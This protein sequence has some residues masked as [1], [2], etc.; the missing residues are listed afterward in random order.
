MPKITVRV[1]GLLAAGALALAVMLPSVALAADPDYAT[2]SDHAAFSAES[3]DPAFWCEN[4]TKVDAVDGNLGF[5]QVLEMDYDKVIVKAGANEQGN[6]AN[7]IFNNPTA[8]QTVWADTN[9]NNQYDAEKVG[10]VDADKLISHIIF[11]PAAVATA[12]PSDEVNPETATPSDDTLPNTSTI[13]QTGTPSSGLPVILVLGIAG[14][15][16]ILLATAPVA[17]RNRR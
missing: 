5:T 7:T 8:G 4:G 12:T 14:L 6:F 9:G 13:S 11:C 16:I 17:K 10:D 1:A 3:N 15:A 2:V